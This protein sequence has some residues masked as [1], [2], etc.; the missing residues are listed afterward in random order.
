MDLKQLRYFHCVAESGSLSKASVALSVGQPS[1]SRHIRALEEELKAELFYRN[2]R[3]IVLT[4]AGVRLTRYAREITERVDDATVEIAS[5]QATPA[6]AIS[7]AM[8][9]SIGWVLSV[10]LIRQCKRDFPLIKLHVVEGFS[11]FVTEWLSNGKIDVGIVY[12]AAAHPLLQVEP[13][14]REDLVVLGPACDPAGLGDGP[15]SGRDLAAIPLI[16]PAH[17]H[18]LRVLIDKALARVGLSPNVDMELDAMAST[19][20]LVEAGVGYTILCE[21]AVRSMIEAGRI[22][23]WSISEPGMTRQLMLATSTQRPTSATT[24]LVLKLVR[25]QVH[26]LFARVSDIPVASAPALEPTC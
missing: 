2:G 11:G 22:R 15:L 3:G 9:P 18:G 20:A 19:L 4:E 25:Q 14:L 16:L 21:A 1:L 8:P 6:G 10:P 7:I 26:D 24:R 13:L 5:L 23:A 17:P 12:N